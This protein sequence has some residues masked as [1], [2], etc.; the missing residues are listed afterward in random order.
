MTPPDVLALT[1]IYCGREYPFDGVDVAALDAHVKV[2][3]KHPLHKALSRVRELE[4]KL[5]KAVTALRWYEQDDV[6]SV[7]QGIVEKVEDRPA[8]AAL[9]EIG[10]A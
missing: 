4:A 1:C 6:R 5:G 8:R 10:E 9:A 3:E 7:E 2:C